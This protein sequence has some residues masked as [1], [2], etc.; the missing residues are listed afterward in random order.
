M[1]NQVCKLHMGPPLLEIIFMNRTLEY[2]CVFLH[3]ASGPGLKP[4]LFNLGSY[5][6]TPWVILV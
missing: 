1:A 3:Q 4:H 6:F 2:E 5:Y